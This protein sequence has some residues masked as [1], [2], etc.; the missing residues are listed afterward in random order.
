MELDDSNNSEGDIL[1]IANGILA[2]LDSSAKIENEEDLYSD[3]FYISVVS[4]LMQVD[5]IKLKPGKNPEEKVKTLKTIIEYLSNMIEADLSSI[6]AEGIILH[7]DKE[8]AKNLLELLFTLIQ[9]VIKANL[10]QLG[11]EGIELDDNEEFKSNSF[12]ENKLNLS[13]KRNKKMR[14]DKDEEVDLENLESLRLE[15]DK[16]KS[17][18]KKKEK[19]TSSKKEK[20]IEDEKEEKKVDESS[21]KKM[22]KILDDDEGGDDKKKMKGSEKKKSKEHTVEEAENAPK[23]LD[24]DDAEEEEKM[25]ELKE[26]EIAD[27]NIFNDSNEIKGGSDKKESRK[28]TDEIPNLLDEEENSNLE[29]KG[30][31]QFEDIKIWDQDNSEMGMNYS[32]QQ[33]AYSVP[34]TQQKLNLPS[35]SEENDL[36]ND[37]DNDYEYDYNIDK[38]SKKE[39]YEESNS[40]INNTSKEKTNEKN[41]SNN[42]SKSN[43]QT[44]DKNKTNKNNSSSKKQG[45]SSNKKSSGKKDRIKDEKK[46]ISSSKKKEAEAN[47]E[48]G[49]QGGD[50]GEKHT[51]EGSQ[52]NQEQ[53]NSQT[54]EEENVELPM[55]D[56]GFKYEIMK[57]FKRIYGDKLDKIFLK[58]NLENSRNTFELALRNIKLAKQKMMKINNRIPEVDDLKTKEFLQKY[59]KERQMMEVYYN[60]EQK[61]LNFFEERAINN[62][63]Q[64]LKDMKKAKEIE[65]KKIEN[66]I[67][68]RRQAQ[69]E[70]NRHNQIKFCNE[71]YQRALQLEKEKNLEKIKKKKE[72]NR[73]ENEEKRLAMERI[74]NYYRDQ[75]RLLREILDNEKKQK[76][77]EHRAHIQF[78]AKLEK[79]KRTEYK[80]ELDNIF[81]RFEQ[82]EKKNEFERKNKKEL[83]KIFDSYYGSK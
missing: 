5:D 4:V 14:I 21:N 3:E 2:L 25:T 8:S 77:I 7:K 58:Q 22:E 37:N 46:N 15:R 55:V 81:D 10:E 27:M 29:K 16:D 36:E 28:K 33:K 35:A 26:K 47:E 70:R 82:E 41:K 17:K 53:K 19:E 24:N 49:V 67:E 76:E 13:E 48:E 51:G 80:K 62:F 66:E 52:N 32:E 50:Q 40:N 64:N 74:E 44:T 42:K 72:I 18:S 61:K 65:A 75:I 45:Q 68:R 39:E 30:K 78:L 34:Q 23:L 56:E 38:K 9:T 73:K 57:E 31:N 11:E 83:A 12:N 1:N 71:I 43:R 69:E 6:E 79:E 20:E 59:E 54:N 63:K 60:R